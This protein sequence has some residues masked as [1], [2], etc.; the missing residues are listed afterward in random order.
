MVT[1]RRWHWHKHQGAESFC[2]CIYTQRNQMLTIIWNPSE[3]GISW[4]PT[5]LHTIKGTLEQVLLWSKC[6]AYTFPC[7]WNGQHSAMLWCIREVF[8]RYWHLDTEFPET[9][10]LGKYVHLHY[11]LASLWYSVIAWKQLKQYISEFLKK[12][13]AEQNHR[14]TKANK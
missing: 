14:Y 12:K 4:K 11:K 2:L 10:I 9:N 8:I 13:M 7:C 1:A 6:Q 5:D 3:W